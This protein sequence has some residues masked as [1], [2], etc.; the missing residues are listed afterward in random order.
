MNGTAKH[1]YAL[2][3]FIYLFGLICASFLSG[4]A[5]LIIFFILGGAFFIIL[6]RKGSSTALLT[7]LAAAFL[8]MGMYRISVIDKNHELN[9][10]TAHIIGKVTERRNP[11]ND[12]VWLEISGKADNVPVKFTLF[13]ADIGAEAGD[14]VEF[15]AEFSEFKDNTYF[16]EKSYYFSKGIFLK[17]YA[18]GDITV[19]KGREPVF[20]VIADWLKDRLDS[21]FSGDVCGIIKAMLF[22]DKSDLSSRLSVNIRRA[23]I[24][25]LTA[26]SGMHLSLLVH[27]AMSVVRRI[28]HRKT[29][30]CAVLSVL[31]TLFLMGLFG[32][33]ASV[34]RSGIMMIIY[35]GS[36]FFNRKTE[37]SRSISIALLVILAPA[38]YACLD[39]GL[40]LSVLGTI[41]VGILSPAVCKRLGVDENNT[42]T[43]A[44]ISSFCANLCTIPVGMFCFGGISVVSVITGL[45]VQIFFMI[46]LVLVPLG[47]I[48]PVGSA[49]LLFAAGA[50]AQIM[51]AITNFIGGMRYSYIE[52]DDGL[53]AIISLLAVGMCFAWLLIVR[54][55]V[56]ARLSAIIFCTLISAVTLSEIVQSDNI[57]IS[58]FSDGSNALV[59]IEDKSGMS[60]FTLS[61]SEKT[62]DMIYEHTASEELSFLC[63]ARDTDNNEIGV[64]SYNCM[65]HLPQ[66]GNTLY[67]VSGRYSA[68]VLDGEM[69]LN[70]R[71]FSV[72][73]ADVKSD[74]ECDVM[75][76]TGYGKDLP[77]NGKYATI[78]CDKRFY[79]CEGAVNACYNET[80]LI[81]NP[82]GGICL[83]YK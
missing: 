39:V 78:L 54:R 63:V 36:F 62:A 29:T 31:I 83:E 20:A 2:T 46:I 28:F 12:T 50:S 82:H 72:G 47:I 56:A 18:R 80:K 27:I 21:C 15:S 24:A 71:G 58:V 69:M 41:G 3:G 66:N 9:G 34:M 70:I 19:E 74:T 81:I 8:I 75:I 61:D 51:I 22:G 49:I 53:T 59:T 68:F 73:I 32:M 10:T 38:P 11:D 42:I 17:A 57:V 4:I 35:Y 65:V 76:Y 67:D 64:Q 40:W 44:V 79:N 25:H 16:A 43:G 26:V 55:A 13:T 45:L 33:T 77:K 5:N 30:A 37:T 1:K 52:L 48:L 7:V 60:A 14:T 23:G 6:N